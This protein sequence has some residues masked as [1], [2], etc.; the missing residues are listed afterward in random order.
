ML[1]AGGGEQAHHRP[2]RLRRRAVAAPPPA[3]V[4]VGRHALAPS[5]VGVLALGQP[6]HRALH[7]R[8]AQILARSGESGE[9]EPR[10]VERVDSP[11]SGPAAVGVLGAAK[12]LGASPDAAQTEAEPVLGGDGQHATRGVGAGRIG[13]TL[14]I[15]ER[16]GVEEPR[17]VV[18]VERRPAAIAALHAERP[19]EAVRQGAPS[20]ARAR[21]GQLLQHGNREGRDVDAGIPVVRGLGRP[22]AGIEL[23]I[24]HRPV[25]RPDD[26]PLDQ[27]LARARQRGVAGIETGIEQ[28]PDGVHRVP[29][30]RDERLEDELIAPLRQQ[31]LEPL[32]PAHDGR[33]VGRE[34]DRVQR[35]HGLDGGGLRAGP[36]PCPVLV[37]QHPLDGARHGA[38]AQRLP[39][40]AAEERDGAVEREEDVAP[41]DQGRRAR[42]RQVL[43]RGLAQPELAHVGLG[44]HARLGA[45]HHQ[46]RERHQRGTG[47]AGEPVDVERRPRRQQD[48]LDR[49]ARHARPRELAEAGQ[50][51]AREHAGAG[52]APAGEDEVARAAERG[53]ARAQ[54][55]E[56]QREVRL[57]AGREV[58]RLAGR[59]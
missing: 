10:A 17:L 59:E 40:H 37:A 26:L 49:H 6:R 36:L 57:D 16:H 39:G 56:L 45:V 28:R 54:S 48:H 32:H 31:I 44:G 47:P 58:A 29:G 12:E 14:Q 11:A 38:A 42:E 25:A 24:V 55:G 19:V 15:G 41:R 34:A 2:R 8:R 51:E 5:P 53:L 21:D 33:M 4:L 3:V 35:Q 20:G 46:E 1:R 18:R 50:P 13:D 43:G 22:P 27:P 9:R 52:Q 7:A 23:G 30:R